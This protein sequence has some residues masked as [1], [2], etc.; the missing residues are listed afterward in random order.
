[1]TAMTFSRGARVRCKRHDVGT[2]V[3]DE[4]DVVVVRYAS[5]VIH[6]CDRADLEVLPSFEGEI[7]RA[8]WDPPAEAILRA[9]ALAIDSANDQWGVFSRSRIELLPH[10]LWVCRRVLGRWPA[11]WL[12]ADDVGL[13]KTVEAG[14]IVL[15]LLARGRVKRLLIL[16]PASIVPQWQARL[17]GQFD[18]GLTRYLTEADAPEADFWNTHPQ[19][20]A[21]FHTLR[22]DRNGRFERLFESDPWDLVIVDE[23]HHL[24]ADER[25]GPTLAYDLVRQLAERNLIVS[26]VFFTGTPHRGKHHAFLALLELLRPDLFSAKRSLREQ[27]PH[28]RDVMIRNNKQNVTDL[29]G[30]RLFR[31]PAVA[32]ETYSYTPA[33]K[34]FY[35]MLTD[36]ILTGKAYANTLSPAQRKAVILVLIS[37]QKL[38]SSSIAAVR[39]ALRGRLGRIAQQRTALRPTGGDR[40]S[41][42]ASSLSD[43]ERLERAGEEEQVNA[44]DEEIGSLGEDALRLMEDEKARLAELIDAADKVTQETKIARLIDTIESRFAGRSVLLFTEYKAT[45]ALVISALNRKYGDGQATFI[46]GDEALEGVGTAAGT[47][48]GSWRE[49]RYA[50]AD[51]FNAGTVRFLVSTEAAGEGIDLQESCH[52]L[53]HVDLPWN[54]MR[55]HQRVGRLNRYGQKHQVEVVHFRNPDTVEARIWDKL[56]QKINRINETFRHTMDE[57]EDLFPLVLGMTPPEIFREVLAEAVAQP[58]EMLSTWFDEKTAQFGGRDALETVRALVGNCAKFDFRTASRLIPRADLPDLEPF[59]SAALALNGRRPPTKTGDGLSFKTPDAWRADPAIRA[60]YSAMTFDRR[61]ARTREEFKRVLGVGHRLLDHALRQAESLRAA[62]TTLPEQLLPQPIVA[63]RLTDRLTGS[64]SAVA[65]VL[66]AVEIPRATDAAPAVLRDWEFLQRLN[67]I[68]G[69]RAARSRAVAAAPAAQGEV[70]AA[71]ERATRAVEARLASLELPFRKPA[72]EPILTFWPVSR[73][74]SPADLAEEADG[75]DLGGEADGAGS[76]G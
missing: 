17:K 4:G 68:S 71:I 40:R 27:L 12:V 30:N 22:S 58:K 45:Q 62:G 25:S 57:P 19:V 18:I 13:G 35:D 11:R 66:V 15:P 73:S 44:L 64:S 31:A 72:A 46:N 50:A 39:K 55:M 6:S 38:A 56:F 34:A 1:M 63:F 16:C 29:E 10:Q 21:S 76:T 2:V 61:S 52:S 20:V 70:L 48:R 51:R 32:P 37:M 24:G 75:T 36:F 8:N 43:Y 59:F 28:L 53:I 42:G 67:A 9:Q 69:K 26:M 54:P 74:A 23:A 47:E 60:N 14:L 49:D 3:A 65:S 7:A 33:E 5:G 41:R